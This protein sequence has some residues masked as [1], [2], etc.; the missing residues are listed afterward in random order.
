MARGQVWQLAT[1]AVQKAEVAIPAQRDD[2][3]NQHPVLHGY[4]LEIC[5]LHPWPDHEI[6]SKAGDVGVF[7]ALCGRCAFE[8]GHG[9]EEES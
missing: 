7:E 4:V 1:P 9:G 2:V 5:K 6:L 8:V 3:D